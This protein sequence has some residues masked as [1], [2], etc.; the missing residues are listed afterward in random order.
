MGTTVV[1]VWGAGTNAKKPKDYD[2]AIKGVFERSFSKT[3]RVY[4]N[5]TYI[6]ST[7]E[8]VSV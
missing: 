4:R 6:A 5:I 8:T 7:T 1:E 2:R 3:C